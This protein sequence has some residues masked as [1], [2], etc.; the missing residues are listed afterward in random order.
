MNELERVKAEMQALHYELLLDEVSDDYRD[1]WDKVVKRR[2]EFFDQ[3]LKIKGLCIE[4]DNQELPEN[5]YPLDYEEL[6]DEFQS[7][8]GLATA[9]DVYLMHYN[10]I[11]KGKRLMLKS[12]FRRVIE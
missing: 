1:D 8:D 10:G 4:S 12:N 2:Y 7:D 3:I 5:P 11:E 6:P 9:E